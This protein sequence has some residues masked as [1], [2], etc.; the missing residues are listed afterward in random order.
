MS[1]HY[2]YVIDTLQTLIPDA[3]EK[4]AVFLDFGC[5]AGR[6]VEKGIEAG[7]NFYGADPY[8][9][10]R[11]DHYKE[12][13]DSK[14]I[15]DGRILQIEDDIL[16]FPDNHFDAVS[17]NMV[18]EHIPDITKPMEEI[19]RVLKPGGVFLALFPTADTLWEGH[20]NLY[21]AHWFKPKSKSLHSYLKFMK[22]LGLGKKDDG[23]TPDEW[24]TH[25]QKYLHEYCFYRSMKEIDAIWMKNYNQKPE[26]LACDHMVYRFSKHKRLSSLAPLGKNP[27]GQFLFKTVCHMRGA[28]VLLVQKPESATS[29]QAQ[30][31]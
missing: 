21:F 31:A 24:A 25:Y 9:R 18:F 30:E 14:N 23:M 5:G 4:Q 6:I 13:A 27:V 29:L 15:L 12:E 11:S 8:P 2:D 3:V 26:S 1:V 28:R 16:P 10:N 7:L 19:K 22:K 20:V 17:T